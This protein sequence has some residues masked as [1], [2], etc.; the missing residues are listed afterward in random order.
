MVHVIASIEVARGK[1]DDFLKEFHRLVPLVRAETGCIE[2]GPTVDVASGI[3]AQAAVR[4]DVVT[5]VEKWSDLDAL[6]AMSCEC[7]ETLREQT[8]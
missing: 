2:Y 6:K 5:I 7:Y 3:G 8:L 4:E 1:R